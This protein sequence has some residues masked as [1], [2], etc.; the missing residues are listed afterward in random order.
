MNKFLQNILFAIFIFVSPLTLLQAS[1]LK[2][3]KAWIREA[4][5]VSKVQAAYMLI[6]NPTSQAV[7]LVAASSPLYSKIEFHRTVMEDGV[8]R[9]LQEDSLNIP[10]R[11]EIHLQPEGAHMMLFNPRQ[12][13]KAGDKVPF[14]L[15][16]SDQQKIEII[17]VVKKTSGTRQHRCG[18]HE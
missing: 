2:V 17:V 12:T 1:E 4:P 11:G 7:E 15:T 6:S 9:M 3:S 5:P 8:M 16:F 18:Q 14:S 13:L 10:A